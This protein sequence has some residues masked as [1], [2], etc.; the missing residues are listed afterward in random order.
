MPHNLT[1]TSTFTAPVAVPSG[2]DERRAASVATPFQALTNR[3][4]WLNDNKATKPTTSADNEVPRMDGV[5]G[6]TLQASGVK[7]SDSAT[8][9][10]ST[11]K[12]RSIVIPSTAFVPATSTDAVARATDGSYVQS[13]TNS[14]H[15]L[16]DVSAYL[17]DRCTITAYGVE[18][19][20]GASRTGGNSMAIKLWRNP[21]PSAAVQ[22][23]S[24]DADTPGTGPELLDETLG[25]PHAVD[26][27]T[28]SYTLDVKVG[29]NAAT[30]PD[31]ILY[32][33]ITVS[34]AGPGL[35]G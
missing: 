34:E 16:A 32:G 29:H 31:S 33:F 9:D 1:P 25:T 5:D 4:E 26:R 11:P 13:A 21:Y 30:N 19:F 27:S 14:A 7:I 22:I 24:G 28:N 10:Y 8:I 3:T 23:G 18:V 15:F 6:K 20:K 2:G 12:V 35:G 17:N